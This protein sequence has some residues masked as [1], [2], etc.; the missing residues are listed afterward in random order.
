MG[1]IIH[2]TAT[3][4]QQWHLPVAHGRRVLA[5]G[6]VALVILDGPPAIGQPAVTE[7]LGALSLSSYPAGVQPATFSGS[8]TTGQTVS[9][10]GLRGRVVLLNFWTTWCAE[11]R[12]EIPMFERLHRDFAAQG[13]TVLGV[14]VREEPGAI[15]RYAQELG[16]SFPLLLD[17]QGKI[18]AAYGAIGLPTTFLIGRDGRAVAL[19]IGPREWGSAPARTIIEALLA[20][21]AARKEA[22]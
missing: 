5:W 16:L 9:L 14:N 8:T 2:N 10:A 4:M 6:F 17:P 7:L 19:A 21:P 15:Q 1:G 11:C 13:L 22:P 18:T 3:T 20:E 12:P